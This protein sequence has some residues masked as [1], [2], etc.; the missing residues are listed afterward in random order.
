MRRLVLIVLLL[1]A[2]AAGLWLGAWYV[3]ARQ[4]IAALDGWAEA[5]RA[6]GWQVAYGSPSATGF[7]SK[8]AAQIPEP[9]LVAPARG[10]GTIAWEWRAPSVRIEI[11]P[12]R[13]DR[14]T[15]RN[16]GEN[17]LVAQ[18]DGARLEATL[19][20][21]DAL[22]R[23]EAG[24]RDAGRYL[25]ELVGPKLQLVDP[26]VGIQASQLGFDLRLYRTPPGDH[27]AV[28]AD[29][30]FGVNDLVTEL[31]GQAGRAPVT[32]NL[33]VELMG[34]IPSGPPDQSVPAWRDDGGTVE[35]RRLTLSSSG[36]R[37]A[38]NGT[39]ALDNQLRPMG[40]AT[41][42]IRGFDAAIDR[43]TAAGSVNPRDAQ[44]AK[45]LLSA[46]ATPSAEG[47]RVLN[48]PLTA[49]DGW[50]YVGPMR[51]TRLYPLKLK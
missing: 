36:I 42:A 50:F 31:L 6:E 44:L 51:L 48:V 28:A 19:D 7:P 4:L 9:R 13:L 38:A 33:E 24:R 12:W 34:A 2:G 45:L 35:V 3:A 20:C 11:V 32:A 16:R 22:V 15:L 23:L 8:V 18:R 17:R 47:E 39:L 14:V 30:G 5:R 43:L 37:V 1:V 27:L 25:I 40:A 21:D 46:I 10:S 49:Q 29:L 26:A 41:A